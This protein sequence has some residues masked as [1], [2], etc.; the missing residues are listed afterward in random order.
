M[1]TMRPGSLAWNAIVRMY[2]F[3]LELYEYA[4][5]VYQMQAEGIFDVVG[6]ES[7]PHVVAF[8]AEVDERWNDGI[9]ELPI[10]PTKHGIRRLG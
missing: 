7:P 10:R 2:L 5:R 1:A 9:R 6:Y 4:K 8:A 3:D